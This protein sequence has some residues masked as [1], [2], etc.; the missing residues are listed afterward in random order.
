MA[1][2]AGLSQSRRAFSGTRCRGPAL[3]VSG[4]SALCAGARRFLS[5]GPALFVG[6]RRCLCVGSS[7]ALC[8]P[9]RALNVKPRRCVLTRH[10]QRRTQRAPGPDTERAGPRH[11]E[12]R[13]SATAPQGL[14]D[15]DTDSERGGDTERRATQR[16]AP[17]PDTESAG[18]RHRARH[19]QR[20]SGGA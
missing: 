6:A 5:R 12:R 11:T 13:E 10:G 14:T 9:Y 19:R 17:G 7:G 15:F 3:S 2:I 1:G 8:G 4:L 16:A 20:K 18:P